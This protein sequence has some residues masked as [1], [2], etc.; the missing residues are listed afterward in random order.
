MEQKMHVFARLAD[1]R[2][3]TIE[4]GVC[5]K[6]SDIKEA[7]EAA[8]GVERNR[9]CLWLQNEELVEERSEVCTLNLVAEATID[10]FLTGREFSLAELRRLNID[11]RSDWQRQ[12]WAAAFE[13]NTHLL[14]LLI[15]VGV[16]I[17]STRGASLKTAL[18]FAAEHALFQVVELLVEAGAEVDADSQNGWT[19]LCLAALHG[20][21]KIAQYL[22][23]AGANVNAVAERKSALVHAIDSGNY[24]ACRVL[25]SGGADVN[26]L[27]L[28]YSPLMYAAAS[29]HLP[30]V[31]LLVRSGADLNCTSPSHNSTAFSL[32]LVNG[33]KNVAKYLRK[34]GAEVGCGCLIS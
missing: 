24:E 29:G 10:V 20:D 14:R 33:R 23:D 1:G 5:D 17:E 19:P 31:K 3:H 12:Y 8:T 32:A 15:E 28:D 11:E 21:E 16:S 22:I 4:V 26:I 27:S 34:S 13:G 25:I 6:V 18:H 30:V 9:Q 2:T 7:I